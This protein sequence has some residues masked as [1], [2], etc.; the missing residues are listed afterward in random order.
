MTPVKKETYSSLG[1]RRKNKVI[2]DKKKVG[3][4]H[5][6]NTIERSKYCGFEMEVWQII[7][8]IN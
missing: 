4:K 1:I 2:R 5:K 8:K 3:D 7:N 6:Q